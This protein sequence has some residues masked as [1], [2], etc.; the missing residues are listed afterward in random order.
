MFSDPAIR[1]VHYR[2]T[3]C[4]KF[5][6]AMVANANHVICSYYLSL[7]T[8][9]KCMDWALGTPRNGVKDC[10]RNGGDSGWICML[11]CQGDKFFYDDLTAS[12]TF[13]CSD[14]G[15]WSPV[16]PVPDCIG[17]TKRLNRARPNMLF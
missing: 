6:V 13:S 3:L 4:S 15:A 8:A 7:V 9:E 12:R 11:T 16:P 17:E 10:V 1:E 14:N 2:I 5:T